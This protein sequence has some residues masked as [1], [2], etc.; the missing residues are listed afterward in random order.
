MWR[1]RFTLALALLSVSSAGAQKPVKPLDLAS[2]FQENAT[3]KMT[4]FARLTTQTSTLSGLPALGG[5]F[6]TVAWG[7]IITDKSDTLYKVELTYDGQD[8]LFIPTNAKALDLLLDGKRESFEAVGRPRRDV[9][10]NGKVHEL[11]NI[12][13]TVEQL[14]TIARTDSVM[15][16]VYGDKGW[17]GGDAKPS[18][19]DRLRRFLKTIFPDSTVVE[20]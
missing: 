11:V 20:P 2:D 6:V 5:R 13:L 1:F 16:R 3:D 4:G 19:F 10:S 7:R 15:W 18:N 8:W 17:I 9:R 14:F 12:P